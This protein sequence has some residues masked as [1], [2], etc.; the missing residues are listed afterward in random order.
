MKEKPS[1]FA[2]S[3]PILLSQP[4]LKGADKNLSFSKHKQTMREYL[5]L[6]NQTQKVNRKTEIKSY[7]APID[8][9]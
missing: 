7:E 5:S 2:N 9:Y 8:A 1:G 3:I 4:Q 6:S